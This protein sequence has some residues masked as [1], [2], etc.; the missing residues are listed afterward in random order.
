M[1]IIAPYDI[2]RF[3]RTAMAKHPDRCALDVRI[4]IAASAI[5]GTDWVPIHDVQS[6]LAGFSEER[7]DSGHTAER[8]KGLGIVDSRRRYC[9]GRNRIEMKLTCDL[10]PVA[11]PLGLVSTRIRS[12]LETFCTRHP[13]ASHLVGLL[14]M[15]IH[16]YQFQ[17]SRDLGKFLETETEAKFKSST[18]GRLLNQMADARLL[19]V[20]RDSKSRSRPF[21]V[22]PVEQ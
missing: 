4:I 11:H 15:G 20:E 16:A 9:R 8:L 22:F 13:A 18:P 17:N 21:T 2:E 10:F 7:Y 12:A 14:L 1:K 3:C 6:T 19:L 5:A